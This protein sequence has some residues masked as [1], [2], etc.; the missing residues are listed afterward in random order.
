MNT[1]STQYHQ[2]I[3]GLW[4]SGT[5]TK[6]LHYTEAIQ[7]DLASLVLEAAKT[8]KN[9]DFL[10]LAYKHSY[11]ALQKWYLFKCATT[12]ASLGAELNNIKLP[13]GANP[14]DYVQDSGQVHMI[15]IAIHTNREILFSARILA[16]SREY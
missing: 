1:T 4:Q 15:R 2:I 11:Q 3:L 6:S 5:M 16:L 9:P 7:D 8:N 10:G 13:K 14:R 12:E